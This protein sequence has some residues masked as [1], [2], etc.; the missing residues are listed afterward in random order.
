[1]NKHV[2]CSLWTYKAL[3][4]IAC[5]LSSPRQYDTGLPGPARETDPSLPFPF[6][7]LPRRASLFL[8]R[9]STYTQ[10]GGGFLTHIRMPIVFQLSIFSSDS[11]I[12]RLFS[13]PSRDL[14]ERGADVGLGETRRW[15]N[16]RVNG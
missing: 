4:Q 3:R 12:F 9:L 14:K 10:Q 15:M 6:A 2:G 16:T 13:S 11:S 8:Q 5:A 7:G 1:M